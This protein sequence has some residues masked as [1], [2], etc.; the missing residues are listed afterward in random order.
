EEDRIFLRQREKDI[1]LYEAVGCINCQGTGYQGRIG[2]FEMVRVDNKLRKLIARGCEEDKLGME[3][4]FLTTLYDDAVAKVLNGT[5]TVE[6]IKRIIV[7][8][9]EE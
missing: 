7:A 5:T 1:T 6:E 3:A 9:E 2:I 4:S 8:R